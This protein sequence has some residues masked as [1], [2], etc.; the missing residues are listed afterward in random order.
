M[1]RHR[2]AY[3]VTWVV[4]LYSEGDMPVCRRKKTAQRRLIGESGPPSHVLYIEGRIPKQFFYLYHHVI[5]NHLVGGLTVYFLYDFSQIH[6]RYTQFIGIKRD[7]LA[8]FVVF[9]DQHRKFESDVFLVGIHKRA[10]FIAQSSFEKEHKNPSNKSAA[11]VKWSPAGKRDHHYYP[12]TQSPGKSPKTV[13]CPSRSHG[14][15]TANQTSSGDCPDAQRGDVAADRDAVS[16][17]RRR[18]VRPRSP[19]A[20]R[21]IPT[22]RTAVHSTA[23]GNTDT[24]GGETDEEKEINRMVIKKHN[25]I[26]FRIEDTELKNICIFAVAKVSESPIAR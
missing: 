8:R 9:I 21:E 26:V 6:R 4:R 13:F 16:R 18:I 12:G 14:A 24:A 15:G 2:A 7:F 3:R 11:D 1:R 19:T 25:R 10:F 22:T 20:K 5:R 23:N 17:V